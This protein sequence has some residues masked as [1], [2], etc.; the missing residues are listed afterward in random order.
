MQGLP[1]QSASASGDAPL[2]FLPTPV[3]AEGAILEVD[4]ETNTGAVPR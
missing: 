4:D 2:V 3:D 1:D